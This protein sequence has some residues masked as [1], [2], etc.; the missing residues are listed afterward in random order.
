[1]GKIGVATSPRCENRQTSAWCYVTGKPE[2]FQN[3][4]TAKERSENEVCVFTHGYSMDSHR[5]AQ[6]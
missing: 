1:M 5:L 2:N 3:E 4:E 6:M